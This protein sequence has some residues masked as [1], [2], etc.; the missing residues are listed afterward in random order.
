[1]DRP[2]LETNINKQGKYMGVISYID[3]DN[4]IIEFKDTLTQKRCL[5]NDFI[6]GNVYDEFSKTVCGI[7]YVGNT[8]T[9]DDRG[10]CKRSYDVWRNMLNRCYNKDFQNTHTTYIGCSVCDEW[11]CYENFEKWY[12]K[13]Y[14]SVS[15]ERMHIDKDILIK[16]NKLYSPETCIIV[17]Q[18]INA[19]FTTNN[20]NRGKY[21]IG[22]SYDTNK[23]KFKATVTSKY[24]N[25]QTFHDTP[26]QAFD[27]YKKEKE[28]VIRRMAEEYKK[29]IPKKLYNALYTYEVEITD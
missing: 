29:F 10:L 14:Y 22:V 25:H 2:Y 6:D 9:R 5:Y 4:V 1:M 17:P 23:E 12:D 3:C 13:N 21:P 28:S 8:K 16:G 20:A 27:S 24:L 18:S 11:L 19:L 15:N 26:E 7:G